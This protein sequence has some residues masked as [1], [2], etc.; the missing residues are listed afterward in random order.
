M[1]YPD[2]CCAVCEEYQELVEIGS[3][4]STVCKCRIETYKRFECL[5]VC[6]SCK[7]NL[8]VSELTY[9]KLIE[10]GKYRG[11]FQKWWIYDEESGKTILKYVHTT[12]IDEGR[13][14]KPKPWLYCV[15]NEAFDQEVYSSDKRRLKRGLRKLGVIGDLTDLIQ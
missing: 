8:Q 12:R 4:W 1:S 14:G 11:S 7:I 15:Y 10:Q 5:N 3:Y 2:K 6:S 13:L 9:R